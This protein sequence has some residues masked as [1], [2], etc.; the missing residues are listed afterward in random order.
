MS[1]VP[2]ERNL[3]ARVSWE[4]RIINVIPETDGYNGRRK[5]SRVNALPQ[6]ELMTL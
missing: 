4:A 2:P 5:V 6:L 3:N 1:G